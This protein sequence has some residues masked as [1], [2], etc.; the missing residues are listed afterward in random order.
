MKKEILSLLVVASF[1]GCGSKTA[2][3]MGGN[4]YNS[5]E[6]NKKQQVKVVRITDIIPAKVAVKE[7]GTKTTSTGVGAVLGAATGAV[8]GYALGGGHSNKGAVVG[9][10]VGGTLGGV[11]GSK[12]GDEAAIVE[13]VTLVYTTTSASDPSKV[14][15]FTS[16]QAG[17]FCEFA[18]GD[19]Y[20]IGNGYETRIQPNAKCQ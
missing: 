3:T 1:I 12:I 15:Q 4:V 16:T 11:G 20:L 17:K 6:L 18:K 10:V 7:A 19:A 5:G 2:D 14:E 9:G 8:I 13:G